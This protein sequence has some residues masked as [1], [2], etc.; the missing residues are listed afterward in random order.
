MT[1][2]YHHQI[3]R[4]VRS[5]IMF[6][7]EAEL[8]ESTDD[9]RLET[10]IKLVQKY[11]SHKDTKQ[12]KEDELKAHLKLLK[13]SQ[14]QKKWQYMSQEQRQNRLDEFFVRKEIKDEKIISLLREAV[15][16]GTLITK[17]VNYDKIKYQIEGLTILVAN[18]ETNEWKLDRAA[19]G[20]E[21]SAV[22]S[23]SVDEHDEDN[24]EKDDEN[25]V[26]KDH[27]TCRKRYEN[28]QKKMM[29]TM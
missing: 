13:D 15:K 8:E 16:T 6:R 23:E 2:N 5:N 18:E 4:V 11:N 28:V 29:R 24:A 25:S 3:D 26:E 10:L 9:T 1:H 20:K 22:D 21:E 27:E 7:F 17:Y 14:Y 19:I 12:I